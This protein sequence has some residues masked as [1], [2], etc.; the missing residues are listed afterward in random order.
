MQGEAPAAFTERR[1]L[2]AAG[3][4][5]LPPSPGASLGGAAARHRGPW[6]DCLA[7][8]GSRFRTFDGTHFHFAGACAYSLAAAADGT[9]AIAIAAGRPRVPAALG[10]L[11]QGARGSRLPPLCRRGVSGLGG[12]GGL[13]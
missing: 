13:G 10:E 11:G 12:G 7:W 4:A 1:R 6:A 5:S 9:W 2:P 8:A 3:E